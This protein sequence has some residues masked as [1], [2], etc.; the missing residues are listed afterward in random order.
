[1]R[2]FA[3]F[4]LMMSLVTSVF[5]EMQEESTLAEPQV[6]A[7]CYSF[8]SFPAT[9]ASGCSEVPSVIQTGEGSKKVNLEWVECDPANGEIPPCE[10]YIARAADNPPCCDR[11]GDTY[12]GNHPGCPTATDCNDTP[13]SG[14]SIHPGATE[15]CGDG[16]D[17]DCWAGDASCCVEWGQP[18]YF[19]SECCGDM[20][21]GCSDVCLEPTQCIP[22]CTGEYTCYE[23]C[24][25]V[26]PIVVDVLG[27]GFS[28]TNA[29]SGVE[30]DLNA[31]D[32]VHR[33]AWTSSNSDE[34][35]LALDRN[36]NGMIDNGR[37]LFGDVAPQPPSTHPNGF[38][39][40]AEF[41]KPQN[42]GSN[43]GVINK[44]DAVFLGLRLWLDM[45]HNGVSEPEELHS[46]QE[47]GLKSIDLTYQT[48]QRTDQYGNQFR[49][50]SKV[51]DT[52]DAQLGRWAWDVLLVQ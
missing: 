43:D 24:C 46:L 25:A 13:D 26:T 6:S 41:D 37:E 5:L 51:R 32:S 42:G 12:P 8:E 39:A 19:S 33:I 52:H 31:D 38:L 2:L 14:A 11:D 27:N 18:C 34:A 21:C 47:L 1:M 3:R 4:I 30:F 45:N 44:K 7:G 49:Y 22:N 35:W 28:L 10:N 20:V 9:C 16:I 50:R 23:G 36:G 17:N 15:I 40:L 29:Q 48:S